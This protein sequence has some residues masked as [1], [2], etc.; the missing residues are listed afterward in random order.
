MRWV[1]DYFKYYL[2]GRRFTVVT[3][4]AL[5][6][7]LN[8]MKDT[9]PRLIWWYLALQPYCFTVQYR[10][11][12]DHANADFFYRQAVCNTVDHPA[13]EGGVREPCRGSPVWETPQGPPPGPPPECPP[14][15]RPSPTAEPGL[16]SHKTQMGPPQVPDEELLQ[17]LFQRFGGIP[18]SGPGSPKEKPHPFWA[19]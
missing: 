19:P 3:D 18:L 6:Q 10:K 13:L 5:L 11:M 7:W 14:P 12:H 8:R 1:I 16:N 9:N 2:W 4:H 17:E 15:Y